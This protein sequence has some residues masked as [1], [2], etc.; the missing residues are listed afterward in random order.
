MSD[1]SKIIG[2]LEL[3]EWMSRTVAPVLVDA[4]LDSDHAC[5]RIPGALNN[6]VFEVGFLDR[7]SELA[8]DKTR[9][10]CLY[11]WDDDSLESRV[12]AEKLCRAG[13]AEVLDFR[14]G[15]S[16]WR[17]AGFPTEDGATFPPHVPI[18]SGVHPLDLGESRVLWAG[19]NLLNKHC[20]S[21]RLKAG[22]LSVESG[23]VVA[24]RFVLDMNGI[25]CADLAGNSLHDVLID[26][27]KSDDFFDTEVFPEAEFVIT[28]TTLIDNASSGAPNLTVS[29]ELTMKGITQPIGFVACAGSTPEGK[30][31]AQACFPIDRTR[32]NVFYGSGKFFRHL[33]GHLVNDLI[34]LELRVVTA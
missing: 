12:A 11:G 29:G 28:Q 9:P 7:M 31:A 1:S 18:R 10:V 20:G 15:L 3:S 6:C 25:E 23:R 2:A 33:G 16:G 32:W 30:L 17:R 26:H 27:L 5:S 34:D 19:R 13:W 8:P 24:G 21:I 4:R 14:E 22:E